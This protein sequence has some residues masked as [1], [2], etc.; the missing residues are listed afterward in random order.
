MMDLKD[1]KPTSS[2]EEI[3]FLFANKFKSIPVVNST[4]FWLAENYNKLKEKNFVTKCTCD[5]AEITFKSSLYL[6]TPFVSKFKDQVIILDLIACN[7]LDKLENAFPIIKSNP[8]KIVS[9]SK[10][11]INKTVRPAF[12]GY[13]NFKENTENKYKIFKE[14]YKN[15]ESL[16]L[17]KTDI[18]AGKLISS[19]QSFIEN[20]FIYD[21]ISATPNMNKVEDYIQI[22]LDY[23]E[24]LTK[25][26]LS[27]EVLFQHIRILTY[28][29]FYSLEA[30]LTRYSNES[31]KQIKSYFSKI[32]K[33]FEYYDSIKQSFIAKF[34]EKFH[35]TKEKIDL[36]KEYIDLLSK[37]FTVQDGRQISQINVSFYTF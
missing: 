1:Y 31:I 33:L 25:K 37:Q 6:A 20:Y 18:L 29:L 15:K 7:Q 3:N 35:V 9:Q 34:Q 32:L 16:R 13:S 24:Q 28:V 14:F 23:K 19:S 36:Y 11:L 5:L 2:L 22:Y 26:K 30:K 8:D 21:Q 27:Y 12:I 10:E 17:C 4:C